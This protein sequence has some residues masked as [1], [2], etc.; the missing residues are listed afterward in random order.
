MPARAESS[1]TVG[2]GGR[3]RDKLEEE[4]GRNGGVN[5]EKSYGDG[6]AVFVVLSRRSNRWRGGVTTEV[7]LEGEHKSRV[8]VDGGG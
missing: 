5:G 7:G 6:V 2:A 1:E 8:A 4:R 3:R